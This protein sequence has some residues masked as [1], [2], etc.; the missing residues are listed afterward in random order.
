VPTQVAAVALGSNL[1]DRKSHLDFAAIRL[2]ALLLDLRVSAYH[3]TTPVDVRGD[4][5]DFLNA[6]A[7]GATDLGARELVAR[8]LAIEAERGR[9][10]PFAGAPRTLD[11]DLILL[12]SEII[13]DGIVAVPHPRFRERWFVLAPLAE[14]APGLLDPVTGRSVAELLAATRPPAGG[15]PDL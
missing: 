14:I 9:V 4:Q 11:L 5:P 1:G 6:A 13:D 2:S 10:R 7:V 12:G 3:R 15:A 8:L